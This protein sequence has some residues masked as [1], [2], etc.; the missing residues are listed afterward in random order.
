MKDFTEFI[1]G[2]LQVPIGG[3]LYTIPPIDITTGLLLRRAM[4]PEDTDA[5]ER[6]IGGD[7]EGD[8]LDLAGY[9]RVLG[10]ALD[11]MLADGVPWDAMDRAYLTAVTDHQRGRVIAEQVWE[12]GHD[13]KALLATVQAGARLARSGV[14]SVRSTRKR[15]NS[16]RTTTS[17]GAKRKRK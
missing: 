6:L 11:E 5:I 9:R 16:R 14:V 15:G 8:E 3:K 2:P 7:T 10:S 17:R 13:P 12:V 1:A 4:N